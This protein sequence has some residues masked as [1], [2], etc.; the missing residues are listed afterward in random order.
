MNSMDPLEILKADLANAGWPWEELLD[1]AEAAPDWWARLPPGEAFRRLRWKNEISQAALG[2]LAGVSQPQVARV[3]GLHD[4]LVSTLDRL[5]AALG[6]RMI[7]IAGLDGSTPR[8]DPR[9]VKS[10]FDLY[11]EQRAANEGPISKQ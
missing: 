1:H 11:L 8:V 2:R 4:C 3:E 9:K 6:Y 7:I 5:Y 10:A